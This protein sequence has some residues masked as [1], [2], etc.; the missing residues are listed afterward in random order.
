M[1]RTKVDGG[2][3]GAPRQPVDGDMGRRCELVGGGD[4]EVKGAQIRGWGRTRDAK[5]CSR[6]EE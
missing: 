3:G 4:L 1:E 2:G 6:R 5:G